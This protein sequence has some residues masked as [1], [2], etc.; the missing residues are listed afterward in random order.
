[1]TTEDESRRLVVVGSSSQSGA[2]SH[3]WAAGTGVL[4]PQDFTEVNAFLLMEKRISATTFLQV[5]CK[6]T[7]VTVSL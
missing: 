6:S 3:L 2:V 5:E 4:N 7:L 1:V